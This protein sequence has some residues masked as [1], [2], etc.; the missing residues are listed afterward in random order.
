MSRAAKG[1]PINPRLVRGAR[2]RALAPTTE[3]VATATG[4]AERTGAG[5]P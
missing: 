1:H 4:G 5:S 3:E 2:P